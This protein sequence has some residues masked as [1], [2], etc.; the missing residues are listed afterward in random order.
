MR[1]E[2]EVCLN[3]LGDV[4]LQ[5]RHC[6][7]AGREPLSPGFV[8]TFQSPSN[9]EHSHRGKQPPGVEGGSQSPGLS[10][11]APAALPRMAKER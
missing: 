7:T 2:L 8:G 1:K 4:N 5:Q 11:P 3:H 6:P 9:Q 10:C